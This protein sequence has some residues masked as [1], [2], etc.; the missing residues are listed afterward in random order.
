MIGVI[1]YGTGNLRSVCN[2]L[3]FIGIDFRIVQH[4]HDFT[5]LHKIILPG[6]GFFG[7][8]VKALHQQGLWQSL[9]EAV[10]SRK[11]PFLGICLGLQLL[12]ESSEESPGIKGLGWIKGQ[13]VFLKTAQI[14]GLS[15]PHVGWDDIVIK[16]PGAL[17]KGFDGSNSF[18]FVHSFCLKVAPEAEKACAATCVYGDEFIAA[19]ERDHIMG[20]QFHPEKSQKE[21]LKVLTNFIKYNG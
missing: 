18:Y 1:D 11:V 10:I 20:V 16:N 19:V 15:V 9:N 5:D 12:A 6:V 2:A 17:L 4:R 8:C 13:V 7:D 3:K 21:G 14:K